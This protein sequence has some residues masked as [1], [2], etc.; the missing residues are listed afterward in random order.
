MS[1]DKYDPCAE[2]LRNKKENF[3]TVGPKSSQRSFVK[4]AYNT[5]LELGDF[6]GKGKFGEVY[7]AQNKITL[8]AKKT[9]KTSVNTIVKVQ[10]RVDFRKRKRWDRM[11]DFK[12]ETQCLINYGVRAQLIWCPYKGIIVMDNCGDSLE[13]KLPFPSGISF[14]ERV[15]FAKGIIN[16]ML[17][18]KQKGVVHC[19]LKPENICYKQLKAGVLQFF[20][21]DFGLAISADSGKASNA[22]SILYL[23]PEV[24]ESKEK[25]RAFSSDL[26]ALAAILGRVFD[27]SD[28]FKLKKAT[29]EREKASGSAKREVYQKVSSEPFDFNGVCESAEEGFKE[30]FLRLL[31]ELSAPDPDLRP[32]LEF[33]QK[34]FNHVPY[35]MRDRERFEEERVKLDQLKQQCERFAEKPGLPADVKPPERVSSYYEAIKKITDLNGSV[36][37]INSEFPS[38]EDEIATLDEKLQ[39]MK[40]MR[41][42]RWKSMFFREGKNQSRVNGLPEYLTTRGTT[43]RA[44]M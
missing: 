23:A 6:I 9:E 5:W 21:I 40:N 27:A 35:R 32:S 2:I 20:F 24:F 36:A 41:F 13:K 42:H 31:K 28:I 44:K 26:Y 39:E 19:D 38:L 34:F 18:L 1:G 17:R 22:G 37:E 30:D 25:N 3:V 11:E 14:T 15:V 29:Y 4:I 7:A 33:V 12:N 10:P 43:L 8:R 16:E